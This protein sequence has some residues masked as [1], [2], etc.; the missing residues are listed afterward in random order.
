MTGAGRPGTRGPL[1][2]VVIPVPNAAEFLLGTIESALAQTY[3]P[4][5]VVVVDD[6]STDDSGAVAASLGAR[7]TLVEQANRGPAAARNSALR[8]ARGE[9]V[10]FLDADDLWA[11]TRLERCVEILQE[12]PEI[13][14]VTTDA[15][16]IENGRKTEKRSYGDRRAFPFPAREDDQI[17]EIARRNFLFVGVVFRRTLL[18]ACG[19]L[20]ERIWGAEDFDLWTRFLLTGSRAAFVNEPLGWYRVRDD[21]VSASSRQW[22]EHLFVLEKHLPAL[23]ELG[24]RGRARDLYEIGEKLAAQ[25]D[26]RRATTFFRRSVFGEDASPVQRMRLA[27]GGVAHLARGA[28]HRDV[29]R[30]ERRGFDPATVRHPSG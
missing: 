6:G 20:D 11:P 7:V 9:L 23:W 15:Y 12:R 2:S 27:A 16:L 28:R 19:E 29:A 21:S 26:R 1:V 4:V 14:M 8:V 3:A 30:D 24:A 22:G 5:E 10:A 13:G 17:A 25:G 18:D